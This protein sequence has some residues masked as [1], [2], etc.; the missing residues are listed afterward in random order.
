MKYESSVTREQVA[1]WFSIDIE[2]L[3]GAKILFA[4]YSYEDYSGSAFVLFKQGRK[5]YEVHGSHCSCYGL[6][7]QWSPEEVTVKELTH[8]LENGY[9]YCK[10]EVQQVLEKLKPRKKVKGRNMPVKS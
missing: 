10:E 4:D 5:L 8:R 3:K 2:Q 9:L 6:E 1:G 7:D